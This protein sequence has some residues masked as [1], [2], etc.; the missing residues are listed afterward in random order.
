MRPSSF[1]A[2]L[3]A[4]LLLAQLIAPFAHRPA[5]ASAAPWLDVC[6]SDGLR[7]VPTDDGPPPPSHETDHC[8]LCRVAGSPAAA[9]PTVTEFL[10]APVAFAAAAPVA[11]VV[12]GRPTLHDAPARAPP[13]AG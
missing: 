12:A 4:L 6:T 7:R 2:A 5:G 1:R 8:V 10:P 3:A 13:R 11:F 9:P